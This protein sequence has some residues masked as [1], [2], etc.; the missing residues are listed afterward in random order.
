MVSC[1]QFAVSRHYA[2][3]FQ[4]QSLAA[5]PGA[6]PVPS[7]PAI[8][9][10]VPGPVL[11]AR[12]IRRQLGRRVQNIHC[13]SAACASLVGQEAGQ[14]KMVT[15]SDKGGRPFDVFV[16]TRPELKAATLKSMGLEPARYN[17][18]FLEVS[19]LLHM[20]KNI[21]LFQA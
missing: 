14:L 18:N 9:L 20:H 4:L 19:K 15:P 11:Q 1:K 17:K 3:F 2:T 5:V 16:K 13:V 12:E 6:A 7:V 10:N 21:N 8:V